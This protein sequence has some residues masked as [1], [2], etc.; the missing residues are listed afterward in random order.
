MRKCIYCK[1]EK[2]DNEFS[3]EHIIPQFLGGAQ[4]PDH[5]KTRHVCRTCNSNLGLFVDASFEKDFFVFHELNHAAYAFFNPESPSPLPL[6]NMGVCEFNPPQ[7][8]ED[9]LCEFWLGPL[10]EQVYWIR[11]SDERMYWYSGGNPRIAKQVK[12]RAYFFFA[13]RSQKNP[14]IPW[15]AFKDAFMGKKVRKVL[16]GK[17]TG[18][19][20]QDIGFSEPDKLDLERIEYFKGKCGDNQ[21]RTNKLSMYINYDMRFM[22]KL[23]IGLSYA[24]YGESV[25]KTE[26]HNEL[27]KALWFK[28]GDPEPAIEGQSC[29]GEQDVFFKELAGVAHGVTITILPVSTGVAI[30]LNLNRQKNWVINCAKMDDVSDL[31]SNDML[32]GICLV[33]FKPIKKCLTLSLP[34]LIAHNSRN[35]VHQELYEIEQ[36]AGLHSKYFHSL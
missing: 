20:L 36:L 24:L 27:Y 28:E 34:Q 4:A 21:K 7:L 18:A 1:S 8:K 25:L 30:N 11:P 29:F 23:A 14:I 22:A 15:L 16:G 10:G 19:N 32:H 33:L 26:Y 5:L 13:E 9:E 6:R 12:T 31:L 17:V 3:L 35:I 2:P